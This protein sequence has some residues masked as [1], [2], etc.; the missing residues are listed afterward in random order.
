MQNPIRKS[1]TAI[2]TP[3]WIVDGRRFGARPARQQFA[4]KEQAE[5]CLSKMIAERG[6]GLAPSRRDKTFKTLAEE[7]MKARESDLAGKTFRGFRSMLKKN[8]L[9]TLG[10]KRVIDIDTPMVSEFLTSKRETLKPSSVKTVRAVLSVIM[11]TA[12]EQR[13]IKSNPVREANTGSKSRKSRIE[14]SRVVPKE[15]PFTQDQQDKLLTWCSA[16]DVELHDFLFLMFKTGCRPG[17]AR[18]L[19]WNK[20]LDDVILVEVSADDKNVVT[21]TKTGVRR[22][23][24]MSPTLK[25]LLR[26]RWLHAQLNGAVN[27]SFIFGDGITPL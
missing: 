10:S 21:P 22:S 13:L 2:G 3:I 12:V 27:E 4:T 6:A 5:E 8:L 15:R 19:T 14:Q 17:E 26:R 1:E 16:N 11:K 9:P 20:V 18:A 7:Y 24:D 25:E 23:V